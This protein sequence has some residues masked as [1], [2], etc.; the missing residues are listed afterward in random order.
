MAVCVEGGG[1]CQSP[2][3]HRR[4]LLVQ[5]VVCLTI[6]PASVQYPQCVSHPCDYSDNSFHSIALLWVC[7]VIDNH[8][9]CG[10]SADGDGHE[11]G[12]KHVW[13][14]ILLHLNAVL[15][16]KI[17]YS[18]CCELE[19]MWQRK[20]WKTLHASVNNHLCNTIMLSNT[21]FCWILHL[22]IH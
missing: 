16:Y 10:W 21:H 7:F 20:T 15:Q 6:A 13:K 11:P 17:N 5:F 1:G 14:A 2:H 8:S 4:G 22:T 18:G 9:L 19:K 12:E 3:I